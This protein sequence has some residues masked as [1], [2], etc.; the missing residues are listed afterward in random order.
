[1]EA[2]PTYLLT[3]WLLDTSNMSL[4][5]Q[6]EVKKKKDEILKISLLGTVTSTGNACKQLLNIV[7]DGS[8]LKLNYVREL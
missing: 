2:I 6:T 3:F 8:S 5:N 7:F 1:M 4:L